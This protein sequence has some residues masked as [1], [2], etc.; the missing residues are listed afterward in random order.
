MNEGSG[1]TVQDLSGNGN[2]GVFSGGTSWVTGTN[3]PAI[4]VDGTNGQIIIADN[5]VLDGYTAM[6]WV[7]SGMMWDNTADVD[8]I[9]SKYSGSNGY[10]SWEILRDGS[11]TSLLISSNGTAGESQKFETTAYT[12]GTPYLDM[13]ITFDSGA[14]KCYIDGKLVDTKTFA[15]HTSIY[16]GLEQVEIGNG[17]YGFGGMELSQV[18]LYNRALSA[19]EIQEL[20][21][22]PF[23]M[24]RTRRRRV[25]FD[26]IAGVP[27]T[28]SPYYYREIASRRIA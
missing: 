14:S 11:D 19:S 23:C 17:V 3:G 21:R 1:N 18:Y 20:Y 5:P 10:R 15:T 24:V 4:S 9:I 2:T 22:E 12:T 7:L 16:A 13:V 25:I 26:E 27:P 6:S 8:S 28:S